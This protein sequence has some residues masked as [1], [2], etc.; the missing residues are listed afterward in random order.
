MTPRSIGPAE[1]SSSPSFGRV[2]SLLLISM[3]LQTSAAYPQGGAASFKPP[4]DIQFRTRDIISEGTRMSAEVFS[5]KTAEV[6]E[7]LEVV[8]P[9]DQ[10]TDLMNA[11]HWVVGELQCDVSQIGLRGSS[12][13]GGHVAYAAARD[14]RVKAIVCQVGAFDS[15]WVVMGPAA[16]RCV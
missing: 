6:K 3:V 9:L 16:R 4:E 13:S 12:Y 11:I 15:R 5:L 14:R 2:L 1:H 8:D 7:V 10:T